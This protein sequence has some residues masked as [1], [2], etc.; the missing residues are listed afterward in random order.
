MSTRRRARAFL[1]S[2]WLGWHRSAM[3]IMTR[4][5]GRPVCDNVQ[6]WAARN[7]G[8]QARIVFEPRQITRRM[9]RSVE[10]ELHDEYT[11]RRV[12][13]QLGRYLVPVRGTRLIGARGL[14][15]LSD[16]SFAAESV[17]FKPQLG[18]DPDYVAPRRRKV[19]SKPGNY[20][21]LVVH[22][23]GTRNY[24]HWFHDT[25]TRLHGVLEYLPS[26]TTFVV[27]ANLRQFQ[28]D[29]LRLMGIAD[30]Q[31]APFNGEEVWELETLHFAPRVSNVG[32]DRGDADIWVRDQILHGCGVVPL[33]TGRRI[34]I[35]R[36]RASQRRLVNEEEV[37]GLLA[38]YGFETV[39][40][41]ELSLRDQAALFAQ[42]E[43]LVST[44][45]AGLT[46]MLFSAS[47]LKVVDM[48]E[49]RM[50]KH[51]YH[52]WTMADELD[53]EYWYFVADSVTRRGYAERHR[54]AAREARGNLGRHAARPL[55]RIP[56]SRARTVVSSETSGL[57]ERRDWYRD[58]ASG[59]CCIAAARGLQCRGNQREVVWGPDR[60]PHRRRQ[61][62]PG[63]DRG[64]RVGACP[65]SRWASTT[66]RR[67]PRPRCAWPPRSAAATSPAL[68]SI[69]TRAAST[70]ATCSPGR[71]TRWV[72]SSR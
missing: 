69:P 52:F 22:W 43:V 20:F 3:F 58:E 60:D 47:G 54:C 26:D 11:I 6:D 51:A 48:I 59:H 71:A 30:H 44:H 4:G 68:S 49:P 33:P 57:T 38:C 19:V 23:S 70:P 45:G 7:Q 53:H 41:E 66:T 40:T 62:L 72:S 10:P 39:V 1:Q 16:G 14:V 65:G 63:D 35:S 37:T 17:N 5:R 24:Y 18:Q 29:S 9:P 15:M 36:R 67:S 55:V 34:F 12:A 42:A 13:N 31:C 25:L 27:S 50:L 64:S 28:Q 61:A 8:T 21:S 56:G 2:A 46:N 32:S